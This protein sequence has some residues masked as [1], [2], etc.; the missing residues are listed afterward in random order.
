MSKRWDEEWAASLPQGRRRRRPAG[1]GAI[2]AVVLAL[3]G[4]MVGSTRWRQWTGAGPEPVGQIVLQA[5]PGDKESGPFKL[6]HGGARYTCVVDGDTIW[7]RGEKIR[8]A[9][10]NAPEISHPQCDSELALGDRARD[11]LMALLNA[12]PF[13][14]V[15]SERRDIDKYGRKLRSISRGGHSLGDMLVREGLAEVWVGHRRDWCH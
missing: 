6:C 4:V 1:V 9:D 3:V 7:Y 13:S 8:I 10:I 2:L 5:G 14:I 11:R 12:G 15:A